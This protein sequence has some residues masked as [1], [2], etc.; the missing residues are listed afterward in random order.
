MNRV[1]AAIGIMFAISVCVGFFLKLI[2]AEA[3]IGLAGAC[4]VFFFPKADNK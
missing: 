1:N 3:F 4:I 2:P